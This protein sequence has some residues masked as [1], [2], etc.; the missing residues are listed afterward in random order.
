MRGVDLMQ[1]LEAMI[2]L[3]VLVSFLSFIAGEQH[4]LAV[5][6]SLYK[7]QLAND[8]WRV[9]YL[10]GDF[11]DFSFDDANLARDRVELDLQRI[12]ELTNLCVFIGGERIT[13]CRGEDVEKLVSTD[14]ITLVD[15]APQRIM[16]T[17]AKRQS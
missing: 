10:R 17:L 7:Y 2:S 15:G 16:V 12:G 13:N 6:D 3:M 1:I 8:V 11:K 5:D 9:L 14:R 4:T